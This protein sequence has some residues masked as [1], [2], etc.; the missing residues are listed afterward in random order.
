MPHIVT[1]QKNMIWKAQFWS[2]NAQIRSRFMYYWISFLIL[3]LSF[4]SSS[5]FMSL[6]PEWLDYL[7]FIFME[8]NSSRSCA[9]KLDRPYAFN[10]IC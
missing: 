10:L 5:G 3:P 2:F 4:F 6:S 1:S 8:N 7:L 9:L